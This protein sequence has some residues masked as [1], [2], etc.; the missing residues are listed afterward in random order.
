MWES[1]R[2]TNLWASIACYRDGFTFTFIFICVSGESPDRPKTKSWF[3]RKLSERFWW[4]FGRSW[5]PP[6]KLKPHRWHLHGSSGTRTRD[7]NAKSQFLLRRSSLFFRIQQPAVV[8]RAKVYFVSK[9]TSVKISL[10]ENI[11]VSFWTDF[12]CFC[13]TFLL[14]CCEKYDSTKCSVLSGSHLIFLQQDLLLIS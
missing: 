8:H 7:R 10:Y 9:G 3:S 6:P 2:L 11:C 12:S 4:N 1:R 14:C 5:R 13:I